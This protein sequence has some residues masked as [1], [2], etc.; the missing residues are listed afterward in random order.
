MGHKKNYDKFK[1][2]FKRAAC[3]ENIGNTRLIALPVQKSSVVVIGLAVKTATIGRWIARYLLV[4]ANF[5]NQSYQERRKQ[6]V[7]TK[8]RIN[9][10]ELLWVRG[11]DG[12]Y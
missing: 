2:A 12:Y 10:Q 1:Q 8:V 4:R 11:T 6:F 5:T 3:G 7:S 9:G